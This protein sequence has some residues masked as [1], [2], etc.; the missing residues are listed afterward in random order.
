MSKAFLHQVEHLCDKEARERRFLCAG[1]FAAK[2]E[3][4]DSRETLAKLEVCY[5]SIRVEKQ[6]MGNLLCPE[7]ARAYF[8]R[9]SNDEALDTP[10]GRSECERL[11]I[12]LSKCMKKHYGNK[13]EEEEGD[14]E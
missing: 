9:C 2:R 4:P 14:A 6:C 12:A 1:A 11:A 7:Q 3:D 5:N 10:E 8:D 13:D